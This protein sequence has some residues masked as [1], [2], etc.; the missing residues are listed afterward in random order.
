LREESDIE[1]LKIEL[2]RLQAHIKSEQGTQVRV[3]DEIFK[4]L[5]GADGLGGLIVKVD[6]ILEYQQAD[7]EAKKE[8]QTHRRFMYASIA[9]IV[10]EQIIV[11]TVKFT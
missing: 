6:R 10:I 4:I 11:H 2:A 1:I 5:R 7:R 9:I 8:E 3:H